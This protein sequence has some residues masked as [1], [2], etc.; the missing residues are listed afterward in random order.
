MPILLHSLQIT[1]ESVLPNAHI[2]QNKNQTEEKAKVVA[3]GWRTELNAALVIQSQDD[4]KKRMNR[5][6]DTW[7]NGRF[8]KMDD[9]PVPTRPFQTPLK[10]DVLAKTFLHI[11]LAAKWLVRYSSIRPI[12]VHWLGTTTLPSYSINQGF[13][14]PPL[15]R[16]ALQQSRVTLS[17]ISYE[18]SHTKWSLSRLQRYFVL[19]VPCQICSNILVHL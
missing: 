5:R 13:C 10:M 15:L 17:K 2:Q 14:H 16:V 11:I 8:G 7:W 18:S 12:P 4:F 6:T 19:L 1:Q 9:H 3:T